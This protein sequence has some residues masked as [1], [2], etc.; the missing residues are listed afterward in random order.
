MIT[1]PVNQMKS[2]S[3]TG[4]SSLTAYQFTRAGCL[5]WWSGQD[6][7]VYYPLI[8]WNR[9]S[10]ELYSFHKNKRV[11]KIREPLPKRV[12]EVDFQTCGPL[13]KG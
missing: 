6:S 13:V 9:L 4:T 12:I 11:P 1:T 5:E 8:M 2:P 3:S 10:Y 7:A